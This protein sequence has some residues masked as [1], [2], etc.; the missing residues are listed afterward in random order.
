ML[1][2]LRFEAESD[3]RIAVFAES[4]EHVDVPPLKEKASVA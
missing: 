2:L 3:D 4:S 1:P